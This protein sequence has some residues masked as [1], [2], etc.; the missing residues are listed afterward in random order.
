MVKNP[1]APALRQPN[2]WHM[3]LIPQW[4]ISAVP[5]EGQRA[6][7]TLKG[8]GRKL[9]L[10]D[11]DPETQS[12]AGTGQRLSCRATCDQCAS[13]ST[14]QRS[15]ELQPQPESTQPARQRRL[16]LNS[17]HALYRP[18]NTLYADKALE[19]SS[20]KT[21]ASNL[22]QVPSTTRTL[23]FHNLLLEE[24]HRPFPDT[25]SLDVVSSKA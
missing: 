4:T 21:S 2:T 5:S 10:A 11:R 8:Q 3:E 18:A 22:A 15:Q 12:E 25:N 6:A 1:R 14:L 9:L 24:C 17:L 23:S 20:H 16:S 7:L 19:Q 13:F